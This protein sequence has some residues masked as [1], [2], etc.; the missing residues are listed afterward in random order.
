MTTKV[1]VTKQR[2]SVLCSRYC[3]SCTGNIKLAVTISYSMRI[4]HQNNLTHRV[5]KSLITCIVLTTSLQVHECSVS[6]IGS[7]SNELWD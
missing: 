4:T 2:T 1:I 3:M 6:S 5:F 7:T